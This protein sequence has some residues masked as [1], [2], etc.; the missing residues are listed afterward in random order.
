[1]LFSY[2]V[3]N[4]EITKIKETKRREE[5]A[6]RFT[7]PLWKLWFVLAASKER[8]PV[9]C[10]PIF[11]LHP[12]S[13]VR[14]EKNKDNTKE[15]DIEI[16]WARSTKNHWRANVLCVLLFTTT[17]VR[18]P[19]KI[20]RRLVPPTVTIRG[21]LFITLG[22]ISIGVLNTNF[23]KNHPETI[24]PTDKRRSAPLRF[25]FSSSIGDKGG[26]VGFEKK[27]NNIIRNL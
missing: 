27:H 5:E 23:E 2:E 14:V 21:S 6:Y 17:F 16:V 15:V 7:R 11:S 18:Y 10:G 3:I 19:N 8:D 26:I 24:V 13:I 12:R 25:D 1:M 22:T 20:I 9:P 4:K